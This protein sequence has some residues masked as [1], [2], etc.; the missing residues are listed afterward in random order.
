MSG[1]ENEVRKALNAPADAYVSVEFSGGQE[2]QIG[3]CTWDSEPY[4]IEISASW[5]IQRKFFSEIRRFDTLPEVWE[6][7]QN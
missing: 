6:W 5:W 4:A 7:L 2:V 1:F 3:D